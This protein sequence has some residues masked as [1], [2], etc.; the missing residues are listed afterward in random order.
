MKEKKYV[1]IVLF[2]LLLSLNSCPD[3]DMGLDKNKKKALE[4][5]VLYEGM[6]PDPG[7]ISLIENSL[8]NIAW[9]DSI[10]FFSSDGTTYSST[11][12]GDYEQRHYIIIT[13][14]NPHAQ[15]Y[16]ETSTDID[17]QYCNGTPFFRVVPTRPFTLEIKQ[18]DSRA[19]GT[20]SGTLEHRF[21]NT[22]TVN[23]TEG[24]FN[25]LIQ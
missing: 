5:L 7:K 14:R 13:I 11:V 22:K 3:P 8:V 17:I 24:S 9:T 19:V 2:F 18:W 15:I 20:I 6:G 16:N 4:A 10:P 12:I 25:I 21:D 23:I 1:V